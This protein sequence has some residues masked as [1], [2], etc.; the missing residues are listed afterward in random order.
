MFEMNRDKDQD[1]KDNLL[2]APQDNKWREESDRKISELNQRNLAKRMKQK[3]T[4]LTARTALT[5]Q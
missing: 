3:K 5:K 2:Y 4:A 1:K